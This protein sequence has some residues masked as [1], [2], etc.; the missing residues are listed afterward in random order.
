MK[1]FLPEAKV[2]DLIESCRAILSMT[3]LTARSLASF[4]GK[5]SSCL[6]AVLPALTC[7][8]AIQAD[9]HQATGKTNNF[10]KKTDFVVRGQIKNTVVDSQCTPVKWAS[11]SLAFPIS[12]YNNRCCHKRG[13]GGIVQQIQNSG[14][15]DS[16]GGFS[17]HKHFK[18]KGSPFCSV[19]VC[20]SLSNDK[21]SFEVQN[22][23]HPCSSLHQSSRGNKVCGSLQ[24]SSGALEVVSAS[25]D[26]SL[27]KVS[28]RNSQPGCRPSFTHFQ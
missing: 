27:S 9:T 2:F 12:V 23:Q 3:S 22:R 20:K 24:S 26:N 14:Q 5:M 13:M 16:R 1:V 7:Y 4:Q 19:I 25:S 17:P 21:C 8:R 28:S 15:V 18:A 10:S 6:H 11:S